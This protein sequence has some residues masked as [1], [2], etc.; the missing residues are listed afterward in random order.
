MGNNSSTNS[1]A[2]WLAFWSGA[3][4]TKGYFVRKSCITITYLFPL[5]HYVDAPYLEWYLPPVLGGVVVIS[6]SLFQ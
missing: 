1:F 5:A 4:K 6:L 2:I 3:G